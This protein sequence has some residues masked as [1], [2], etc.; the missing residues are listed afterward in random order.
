MAL[1]EVLCKEGSN[2]IALSGK[3]Q[4]VEVVMMMILP[5]NIYIF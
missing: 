1:I 4:G 3:M 5:I 2:N